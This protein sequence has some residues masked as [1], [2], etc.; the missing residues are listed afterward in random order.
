MKMKEISIEADFLIKKYETDLAQKYIERDKTSDY[1]SA[2]F[3]K[4][5]FGSSTSKEETRKEFI[6]YLKWGHKE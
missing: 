1:L 4:N 5:Y 6:E 2:Y 3:E